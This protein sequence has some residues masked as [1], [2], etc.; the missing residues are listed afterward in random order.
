MIISHKC[1]A[2]LLPIQPC[3]TLCTR[4][5]SKRISLSLHE[6]T[7]LDVE[8]DYLKAVE[9][10]TDYINKVEIYGACSNNYSIT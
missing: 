9:A 1:I 7:K 2:I 3:A 5:H 10:F 8:N 4:V 6:M